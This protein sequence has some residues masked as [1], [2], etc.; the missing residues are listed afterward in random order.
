MLIIEFQYQIMNGQIHKSETV[1]RSPHEAIKK[2]VIISYFWILFLNFAGYTLQNLDR[3]SRC[4]LGT[5]LNSFSPTAC[6][7]SF[8][9]ASPFIIKALPRFYNWSNR[10][11]EKKENPELQVLSTN[12]GAV[13]TKQE[14][15][16]KC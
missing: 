1:S 5:T 12:N 4:V 3:F 14:E 16:V 11:K 10:K 8:N 9:Y 7:I 15:C 13:K 6:M 2:I